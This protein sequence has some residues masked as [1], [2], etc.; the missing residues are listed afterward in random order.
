MTPMIAFIYLCCDKSLVISADIITNTTAISVCYNMTM[1]WTMGLIRM[2]AYEREN[3]SS[4]F[5]IRKHSDLSR[6]FKT[7]SDTIKILT[8]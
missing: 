2:I 4:H 1:L 3:P 5:F 6:W 7:Q 8:F